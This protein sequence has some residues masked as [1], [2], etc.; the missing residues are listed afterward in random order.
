MASW[1]KLSY[2]RRLFAWLLV[3]SLLLVTCFTAYQYNREKQFKADE[4]DGRLQLINRY[5]ITEL[6]EGNPPATLNLKAV[7]PYADL[8]ISEIDTAGMVVFDNSLDSLPGGSH[9]DRYEIRGAINRGHACS[10]R[11]HSASTGSTYFYSATLAPDGTI[12]RTAVPYSVSLYSML[13]AD[14]GFLWV[15]GAVALIFCIIGFFATRRL[16]QHLSR[17]NDFAARAE[18]G[19][20][21]IDIAPFPHD[22]L[23]DISNNI[24]RLYARL[25]QALTSRDREHRAALHEQ[26]EKERIKKQLTNNINHELKTPVAAIAVCLETMLEH[27]NM[28]PDKRHEFLERCYSNTE[29]L[30]RL[31]TD[32]SLITRLDDGDT[33]ITRSPVNLA[34][35]VADVVSDTTPLATARGIAIDNRITGDLPFTGNYDLLASV[36]RNLIDNAVAYSGASLISLS[37]R[38]TPSAYIMTV[39]DNG[40]GVADEHLPRLFERFYRVDKG[41]SR[42]AGGTGLGLAIVKNVILMHGGTVDVRRGPEG[43]L[44]FTITLKIK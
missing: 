13:R 33:A 24:V 25:Q 6:D 23:G 17:L 30:Q 35:I 32:V 43:G 11:R 28:A 29:R 36:F 7:S 41:R 10:V 1:N 20:R 27:E 37:A 26:K 42:A 15:M 34:G 22:E 44:V 39:A 16:G 14:Y 3:Y 12:V 40:Y 31:L 2:P 4:L 19:E 5:I 38:Q 8:R 21:I 18:R 9:L